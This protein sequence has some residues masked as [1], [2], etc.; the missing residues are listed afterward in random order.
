MT[1]NTALLLILWNVLLSAILAWNLMRTPASN[2]VEPVSEELGQLAVE[3]VQR[4]TAALK[5][6]RIA[7]FFM[8]SVRQ[9]F[10]L[11]KDQGERYRTEGRKLES[12]LQNEMAKAQK[13]YEQLMAKDHTYST[14]TEIQADE[15]ELQGLMGR[16][17]GLQSSSE[18]RLARLEV[19]MLTK[20]SAEIMEFLAEYNK[21]AGLDFIFS[22]QSGGQI[23]VGNPGLDISADV[24][25]GLNQRYRAGQRTTK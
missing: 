11:V 16:I 14:K 18:E 12:E 5:D 25:D 6:A 10:E 23:W 20:I 19:E 9:R 3:P 7:Y 1:K 2:S 21:Q 15:A 22:V 17:Q 24:I 4:D 13:R 8:D